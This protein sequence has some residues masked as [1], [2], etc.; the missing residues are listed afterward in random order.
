LFCQASLIIVCNYENWIIVQPII[1]YLLTTNWVKY[2]LSEL[3]MHDW[4]THWT[5]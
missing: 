1:L 4:L 5:T 3:I 2:R